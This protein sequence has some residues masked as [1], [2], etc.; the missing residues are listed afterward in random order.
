MN[1]TSLRSEREIII[2]HFLDSLVPLTV[3]T[4]VRGNWI[5]VGTGAGFPG[6]VLKIAEPNIKITLVDAT[7][8][9]TTFLHH[10]IGTLGLSG[11]SVVHSRLEHLK[12]EQWDGTYDSLFSRALNPT[13]VINS[14]RHLV[15]TGGH[16]VFF[17]AHT[18]AT[19]WENLLKNK[20]KMTLQTIQRSTLPLSNLTRSLVILAVS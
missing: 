20:S 11:L 4:L 6:L 8:K 5:D 17:Q 19:Q 9:K 3:P 2:K 13:F 16:L 12:G 10:V 15:R 14:G 18:D 1:L 7:E